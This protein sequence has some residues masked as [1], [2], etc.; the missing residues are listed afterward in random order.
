[1]SRQPLTSLCTI[2]PESLGPGTPLDF[3]FDYVDISAVAHGRINWTDVRRVRY[4]D[5]PSRA[6]R[7]VHPGDVLLCTVRPGLKAHT[8]VSAGRTQATVA[9]T[10]FAVLRPE[11][12]TDTAYVFHQL[13]SDDVSAQLRAMETGSNYPA[14]NERDVARLSFYCPDEGTR[15][16]IAAVLDTVDAAIAKTEAAIAKLK[17]VRA[18]LLHDLLTRGLDENG[19]LRPP[20]CQAPHLYQNSPLGQ[21]P[22][23]WH[24][25][26]VG[27]EFPL[28]RGFDITVS[29]QRDGDVPVV[30]S[31]GINSYHDTAMVRGPGVVTGRKGKLGDTYFIEGDFWPHDTSLWVTDFFGNSERFCALLLKHM[32]LERLDAATSVPTLNRNN[33]H[34]LTIALPR[35]SEQDRIVRR[36]SLFDDGVSSEMRLVAK[37]QEIKS[38]LTSDLLT[39][40]VRV[41]E[42]VFA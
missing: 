2:N 36:V 17:C 6:R 41:P 10:G 1:M 33:V 9:S 21:V 31:S 32:R 23:E 14:V 42:G 4:A 11:R 25:S 38:G 13:F 37:M 19:Q 22:R 3:A 5:A 24:I 15:G 27:G 34:P 26:T 40:R 39:G 18:G 28:Q 35:R 8:Q 30:S 29:Q 7:R 16:R 20:H 12:A